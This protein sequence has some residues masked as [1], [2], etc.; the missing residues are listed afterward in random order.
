MKIQLSEINL[1]KACCNNKCEVD[2]D[3]LI[4][5]TMAFKSLTMIYIE[6]E[7]ELHDQLIQKKNEYA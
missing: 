1:G 2:F 5:F 6:N 3:T 4:K 7:Q